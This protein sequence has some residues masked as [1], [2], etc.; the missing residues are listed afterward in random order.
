MSV[1]DNDGIYLTLEFLMVQIQIS[2]GTADREA[3]GLE[4]RSFR[5]LANWAESYGP[6]YLM[7]CSLSLILACKPLARQLEMARY[8]FFPNEPS[9]A[10]NKPSLAS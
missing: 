4:T 5:L 1:L 9:R 8:F 10:T 6:I 2:K 7:G 3:R